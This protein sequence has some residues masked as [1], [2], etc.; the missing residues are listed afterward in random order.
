MQKIIA[1]N[2]QPIDKFR[3]A[4]ATEDYKAGERVVAD[5]S[6]VQCLG[7]VL[8]H[9]RQ[10]D[11]KELSEDLAQIVRRAT[12]QDINLDKENAQR[13]AKATKLTKQK[14]AE[15]GLKMKVVGAYYS[16]DGS[17]IVI[18]FTAEDRVD[19]REL[20]KVLA[21]SLH[22]R[23][24]LRQIGL[25]DEVKIKGGF[26]PCG[27]ICCCKRFL[28][29][30]GHVSVKMAKTQGLSLSPTKIS[31]LCGRLMCCLAYENSNYEE[32]LKKMPKVGSTIATPSGEGTVVYNDILREMVS[33][34]INGND[35]TT[36][37]EA[38]SLEELK[39]PTIKPKNVE[40]VSGSFNK[41]TNK[42]KNLNGNPPANIKDSKNNHQN[43][44]KDKPTSGS[45]AAEKPKY[46]LE[47]VEPQEN[48]QVQQ[49]A[50]NTESLANAENGGGHKKNFY[51]KK[52]Y[53]KKN[54]NYNKNAETKK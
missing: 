51:H 2:C 1:L 11:E 34:R 13:A 54:S 16:L 52:H 41:T 29:D 22:A 17:K 31:G 3:Y 19:F 23:I 24:E 4:L 42:N 21:S 30:F 8:C 35:D 28:N 25:R 18:D 49:N 43:F 44:S 10:V 33:V 32:I 27:E 53:G 37:I 48:P 6:G 20:L 7:T 38:F 36:S 39:N 47:F 45:S 50:A 5:I 26:G 12:E 15:L 40:L 14:V 9:Y 46:G